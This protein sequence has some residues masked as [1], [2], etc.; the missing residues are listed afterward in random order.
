M[1]TF[2]VSESNRENKNLKTF[3][4][5]INNENKFDET[6]KDKSGIIIQNI[7]MIGGLLSSS[8]SQLTEQATS[9]ALGRL[10][11]TINSEAQKWLSQFGTAK[12]NLSL[13]RKGKLDNSSIDLLLPLYDNK[14]DWLFFSQL[15]Y[16]NKDSRHTVNLGLGGRYFTSGWMYGLNTFFDHDV[17]GRNKRLGLGGEAWTDYLKFSAN[18]Y[19][20]LSKWRK[21]LKEENW[22]ERPANGFDINGEFFLP[23]YP[24]LGGKLSYEQYF[25]DNVT[26][27]NRNT[28]QKNPAFAKVGLSYTPVPLITMGV[29][30]RYG[31]GGHSEARFQASLNYR[32]GVPFSAQLS[33]D[34]VAP[35][36]TLA[37]SR[38]DLVERNNNIVLDHRVQ[39]P[40]ID[41]FPKETLYGNGK[42]TYTYRILIIDPNSGKPLPNHRL[43]KVIWGFE[44]DRLPRK[45]LHFKDIRTTTDN[46]GY[47]T[48]SLVSNVGVD[49]IIAKVNVTIDANKSYSIVAKTPVNFKAVS[50]AAGLKLISP[51]S[52]A[53]YVYT[54]ETTDER[55]RKK[56]YNV[57]NNLMIKLTKE[58]SK[59][60]DLPEHIAGDKER[61]TYESSSNL[62]K[63]DH[64][65]NITFPAEHFNAST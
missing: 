65:G 27:F 63:I 39:S 23:A 40:D 8:S 53:I 52:H 47:L 42:D 9:Y 44:N 30:Y 7:Q 36:R 43:E 1:N 26:L 4:Q 22:E 56:P 33:P 48:A 64:A 58:A 51:D 59:P 2:S 16:R 24:N 18:A 13:D 34:N 50:Q 15:G 37:G 5:D 28:K 49:D 38:Y 11:G 21:S 25:G 10:N 62:V 14:A 29:D 19:L 12:V 46:E 55:G 20:R 35:M 6:E 61:V 17:T 57:F 3:L 41:V 31:R 60:E 32:F 54:N 45:D